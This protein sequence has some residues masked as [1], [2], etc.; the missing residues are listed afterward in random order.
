MRLLRER[1][2][3]R[4]QITRLMY[5]RD[6]AVR[7]IAQKIEEINR[8]QSQVE[9]LQ[10]G[11]LSAATRQSVEFEG[12]TEDP[13]A[14]EEMLTRWDSLSKKLLQARKQRAI[15]FRQPDD[16]QNNFVLT[17]S[18]KDPLA[19]CFDILMSN[20]SGSNKLPQVI[21]YGRVDGQVIIRDLAHN[22]VRRSGET[23]KYP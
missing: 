3:Y 9:N 11:Q 22:K 15:T 6:G 17:E 5:V 12:Q 18:H 8:L 16:V 4:Q 19:S 20:A 21:V 13:E 14:F 10:K 23:N 2:E 7:A 1:D